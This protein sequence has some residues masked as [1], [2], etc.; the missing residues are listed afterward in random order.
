MSFEVLQKKQLFSRDEA[1]FNESG[2]NHTIYEIDKK[3][4]LPAIFRTSRYRNNEY[5]KS[6]K[7]TSLITSRY[8]K[9]NQIAVPRKIIS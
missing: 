7:N 9:T 2:A 8:V 5:R 1:V 6:R 3:V 4:K